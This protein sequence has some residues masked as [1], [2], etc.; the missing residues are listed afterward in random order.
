[1]VALSFIPATLWVLHAMKEGTGHMEF[2]PLESIML[3]NLPN[4][5]LVPIML[6]VI[7]YVLYVCLVLAVNKKWDKYMSLGF[8]VYAVGTFIWMFFVIP[9]A[10]TTL[11][12]IWG[13][14]MAVYI[15]FA[16]AIIVFGKLRESIKNKWVFATGNII[17]GMHTLVGLVTFTWIWIPKYIEYFVELIG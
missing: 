14:D 4:D 15:L 9:E 1:M 13:Y 17:L 16:M 11:D 10:K 5:H 7:V 6:R 8:A 12:T 2:S 3:Y